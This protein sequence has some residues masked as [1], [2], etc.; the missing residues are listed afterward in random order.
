LM[1]VVG[2]FR[3]LASRMVYIPFEMNRLRI[4][5]LFAKNRENTSKEC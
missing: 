5:I 3:A 2:V 1:P 4:S